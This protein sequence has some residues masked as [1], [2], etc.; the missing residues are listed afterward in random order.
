MIKISVIMPVYNAENFIKKCLNSLI[1]QTLKDIEIIIINDGSEDNSQKIIDEYV[2]IDSRIISIEKENGGVG[3]AV[4][5]GIEKA[6]GQ[7]LYFID[8]DD[9]LKLDALEHYYNKIIESNADIYIGAKFL[10]YDNNRQILHNQYLPYFKTNLE[11]KNYSDASDEYEK[12]FYTKVT[13]H[14]K[15]FKNRNCQKIHLTNKVRYIVDN[16]LTLLNLIQANKVI[17]DKSYIG[18]YHYIRRKGNFNSLNLET[19]VYEQFIVY[20]DILEQANKYICNKKKYNYLKRKI[21][22]SAIYLYVKYIFLCYRKTKKEKVKKL[23]QKIMFITKDVN[24]ISKNINYK[25]KVKLGIK[26]LDMLWRFL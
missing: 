26:L 10:F 25:F 13:P 1:N 24:P 2:K 20:V 12:V 7:F 22:V 17:Y 9:W 4:S 6:K 11:E 8:A 21:K 3:T 23:K 19:K 18:S 15:L 16:Q 5:I 14:A